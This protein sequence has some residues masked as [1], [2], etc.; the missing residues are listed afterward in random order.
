MIKE[1]PILYI[2]AGPPGIGKSTNGQFFIPYQIKVLNHDEI[3][4]EFKK[5]GILNY[6]ER[7]NQR[8][9]ELI[10]DNIALNTGF[11]IELNLGTNNQYGLLKRIHG[12]CPHY[13]IHVLLF[14]TDFYQICLNRAAI[15]ANSGGHEVEPAVIRDMCYNTI[16]LLRKNIAQFKHITLINVTYNSLELVYSGYYPNQVHEFSHHILPNWIVKNFPEIG[17]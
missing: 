16:G 15:R 9:W 17:S 11:G 6:E 7:A 13:E 10:H 1:T 4:A 12:Y 14:F 2:I 8:I 3:E 5:M